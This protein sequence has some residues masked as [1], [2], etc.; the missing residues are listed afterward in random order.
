MRRF[1]LLM[2]TL[3]TAV[4]VSAQTPNQTLYLYPEGPAESNGLEG[5]E[6]TIDG[7]RVCDVSNPRVEVYL[8]EEPNGQAVVICPGGGYA[9]LATSHE[10]VMFAEWFNQRG[11]TAVILYYRMPNG[12]TELPRKDVLTAVELVRNNAEAWGVCPNK[13]GIMGFSAGG[14]VAATAL[15]KFSNEANRPDFG[16]LIYPVISMKEEYTHR[17]SRERLIGEDAKYAAVE[18][19]SLEECVTSHTPPCFLA[20]S[21]DDKS[22]NPLNS[23]LFYNALKEHSVDAELHIYPEGGHGWGFNGDKFAPYHDEFLASLERWMNE[24]K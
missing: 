20:L 1:F 18:E 10:G 11:I 3:T 15:T 13:V 22:V 14:H 6:V 24:M 17:G 5:R 9:R 23:T 7:G 12:H 19:W 21:D 2:L 4:A 16:V 8:P